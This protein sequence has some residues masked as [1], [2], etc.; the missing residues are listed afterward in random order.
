MLKAGTLGARFLFGYEYLTQ[1]I[2]GRHEPAVLPGLI[3]FNFACI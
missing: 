1:S 3:L 2:V